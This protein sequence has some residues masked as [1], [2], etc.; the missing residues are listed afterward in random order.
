[1]RI[2]VLYDCLYPWTVGGAERWYRHV[3]LA[4][5]EDGHDVTYATRRQWDR[6][7]EPR[8]EGVDIAV[9]CP[10][11]GLY[12][13]TGRRRM[14]EA[15]LFGAGTFWHLLRHGRGYDVVHTAS[16][17][18]FSVLAAAAAR[19][20]APPARY[21]LVVDWHELWTAAYWREYVGGV[22]GRIGWAIQRAVLRVRQRAFCFAQVT[23]RR[24]REERVHGD[25]TVLEG[26]WEGSLEAAAPQ[27]AEDVAVFAGRLIREKRAD[28]LGPA[29]TRARRT[30]PE[31]R[32]EVYGDGPERP[33]VEAAAAA[34]P[35]LTV[36]G[37]VDAEALDAALARALCLVL[38]SRRE[39]YGKVVIEAAR[40]GVPSVVVDD[41]DS[42]AA[43]LVV[44]GVNGVLA[45]SAAPEDLGAAILRVREAGPALRE[46]TAAW[47][48]ANAERLS[49]RGSLRTL[50]EAYGG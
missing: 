44:D 37:F 8:L 43:E 31:L 23:A 11:I 32:A 3:A 20:L 42:A 24:L 39:G 12:T 17:P 21:R 28:A 22:A 38:P 45:A 50:L 41:S 19:T 2:L 10:R 1:L 15:L 47:F 30:A 29:V 25:V 49:L 9:V 36:H 18:Y 27:P 40:L 26:Q 13:A 46:S 48:T 5:A 16:F 33:A 35:A 34:E 4:L 7:D 14:S 6:G